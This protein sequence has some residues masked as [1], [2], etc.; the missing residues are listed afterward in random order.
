MEGLIEATGKCIICGNPAKLR[1]RW[2]LE[3]GGRQSFYFDLCEKCKLE[4]NCFTCRFSRVWYLRYK[5][6]CDKV[7]GTFEEDRPDCKVYKQKKI[8]NTP[9][10]FWDHLPCQRHHRGEATK[11]EF[12]EFNSRW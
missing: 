8:G 6:R 10:E 12:D 11:E 5:G 9:K 7:F 1:S 4:K 2:I 3:D